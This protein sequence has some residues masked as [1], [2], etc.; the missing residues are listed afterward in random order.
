MIVSTKPIPVVG[1]KKKNP[2]IT[3]AT[4]AIINNRTK[5]INK[6]LNIL[7]SAM[8]LLESLATTT[9]K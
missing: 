2:A 8:F 1:V 4:T 3:A 7:N 9:S 5:S 6:N